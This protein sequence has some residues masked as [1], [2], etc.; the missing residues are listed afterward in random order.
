MAATQRA[1]HQARAVL[2]RVAT[3]FPRL[4]GLGED[5][6]EHEAVVSEIGGAL[7]QRGE[8]VD[9]ASP[10]LTMLRRNIKVSHDR[11]QAKL[12]EFLGSA[13]GRLA[14]QE[15]LVTLRDGRYVIPVKA[16][17]RGEVRGIVHDVSSSG[18]TVFIEPLA[19]V[20]LGNQWREYQIEERREVERILRRLSEVVG[21]VAGDIVAER[22]AAGAARPGDVGGAAGGGALA[23]GDDG[24]A[25]N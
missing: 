8:V 13:A 16:D 25:G 20:E 18:A 19:V 23:S 15:S 12:Q 10:A 6:I 11:L 14:A 4:G 9:G 17:F 3:Q 22:G 7:D 2:T 1:A 24:A 21:A 5:L